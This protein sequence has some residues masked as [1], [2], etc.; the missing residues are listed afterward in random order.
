MWTVPGYARSTQA[1]WCPCGCFR[2][3]AAIRRAARDISRNSRLPATLIWTS[4][5]PVTGILRSFVG[6]R[7]HSLANEGMHVEDALAHAHAQLGEDARILVLAATLAE[8]S[9]EAVP[10]IL[11]DALLSHTVVTAESVDVNIMLP[12]RCIILPTH[13]IWPRGQGER[14]AHFP[15]L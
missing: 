4:P 1:R 8:Q 9:D 12:T 7:A 5:L 14:A 15:P 2:G 6:F 10:H 3:S 13:R 11:A